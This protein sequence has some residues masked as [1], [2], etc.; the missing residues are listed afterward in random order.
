[1]AANEPLGEKVFSAPNGIP[2]VETL[3]KIVYQAGVVDDRITLSQ[4]VAQLAE[5]PAKIF[6]LYPRKGDLQPGADADLVIFDPN[7]EYIIT[8]THP[9]LNVDFSLYAGC[10]GRGA[11]ILTMQR[12]TILFEDNQIKA[13]PG[14]GQYLPATRDSGAV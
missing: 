14:Q 13:R 9:E 6:G 8:D 1:M 7:L 3:L 5:N 10:Q 11:P 2:G 4:M 12:G